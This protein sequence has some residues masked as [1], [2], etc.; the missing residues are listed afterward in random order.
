MYTCTL[1]TSVVASCEA[2]IDEVWQIVWPFTPTNEVATVP[3]GADFIGTMYTL[4]VH[5]VGF[6]LCI[7]L[8]CTALMRPNQAETVLYAVA[9]SLVPHDYHM[10]IT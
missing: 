9:H 6:F 8:C 1:Y 5:I 2:E 7:C 10:T 4:A 3:C